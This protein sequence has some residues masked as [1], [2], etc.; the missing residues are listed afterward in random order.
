MRRWGSRFLVLLLLVTAALSGFAGAAGAEEVTVKVSQ[1][2]TLG[3][4]LTDADGM[5]LYLFTK[6]TNG[7]S[8]CYGTC[9]EKWPPLVISQ[10]QTPT[11]GPGVTG[12]LGT[13]VRKDGSIQVTYEGWPLYYWVDDTQ[14]GDATGQG[15]GGVWYVIDPAP[16]TVRISHHETFGDYLT[17]PNGMTLYVFTKDR[18][19][20]SNCSGQCLANWPPLILESGARLVPPVGLKGSLGTITRADGR[21]QVTY[22]GMPLYYWYNDKKAGDTTGHNVNKVWFVAQTGLFPD[23]AGHWASSDVANAVKAGWVGG[24]PD[25]SFKPE[26]SVTRAEFVK[27]LAVAF[28][29]QKAASKGSFTD[30]A[31]HWS[32]PFVEMAVARGVIVPAEYAGAKFEPDKAITRE[33]IAVFA[34]RA[35]GLKGSD[36]AVLQPFADSARVSAG[37]RAHLAAAVSAKILGGYP[38]GTIKPEGT[39]T[40]GEAVVMIS[41]ALKI[42]K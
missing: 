28:G 23:T 25:G 29:F 11:A 39:A 41:R 19:G 13:T 37:A 10:G 18:P 20:V 9:E 38:D 8:A 15:V 16:A 32:E 36:E 5:T 30:T 21:T 26:G 1:H 31:G 35:A 4:I 7:V 27:M 3:P 17:G 40:R 14:P 22:N 6:D 12:K 34:A 2:P 33:E 42:G 24:Y